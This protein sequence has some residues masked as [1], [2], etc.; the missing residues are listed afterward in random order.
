MFQS[1]VSMRV[2]SV[3]AERGRRHRGDRHAPFSWVRNTIVPALGLD[4]LMW[5]NY[6]MYGINEHGPQRNARIRARRA[7][8]QLRRGVESARDAEVHGEQEGVRSREA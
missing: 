6:P 1:L 8:R 4:G 3:V 2:S 7:G 5:N